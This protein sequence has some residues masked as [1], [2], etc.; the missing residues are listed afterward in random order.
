MSYNRY[1][2]QDGN[3]DLGSWIVTLI[4]LI[5]PLWF[6]GL[7]LLFRKLNALGRRPQFPYLGPSPGTQGFH[8]PPAGAAGRGLGLG[9]GKAMTIGGAAMAVIFGIATAAGLPVVSS[10]LGFLLFSPVAS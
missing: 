3:G 9:K 6:V 8:T 7:I 10:I 2:R 4:L 5:S 1:G